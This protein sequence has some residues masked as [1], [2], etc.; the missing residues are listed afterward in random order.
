ML[1]ASGHWGA[2]EGF[3][4]YVKVD[5]HLSSDFKYLDSKTLKEQVSRYPVCGHLL[6]QRRKLTLW[7]TGI[8]VGGVGRK[9]AVAPHSRDPNLRHH[10]EGARRLRTVPTSATTV[11]FKKGVCNV[12]VSPG[13]P[14]VEVSVK[15]CLWVFWSQVHEIRNVTCQLSRPDP[16]DTQPLINKCLAFKCLVLFANIYYIATVW[17]TG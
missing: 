13:A 1:R 16:P 2:H 3:P 9:D 15:Y 6:Q 12:I 4:H 5:A 10:W 11:S 17:Q 8:Q 14:I 7:L